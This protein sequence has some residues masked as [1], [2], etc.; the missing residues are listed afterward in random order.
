MEQMRVM[1]ENELRQVLQQ[2]FRRFVARVV[3]KPE[4]RE[5]EPLVV[6]VQFQD[7]APPAAALDSRRAS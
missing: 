4:F 1:T 7:E 6:V 5:G 3:V 2:H